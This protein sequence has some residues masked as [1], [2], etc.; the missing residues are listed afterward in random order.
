M[1]ASY[2]VFGDVHKDPLRSIVLT[3]NRWSVAA[4]GSP[5]GTKAYTGPQPLESIADEVGKQIT[6]Y[7]LRSRETVFVHNLL[8]DDRFANADKSVICMPIVH[9]NK[10]LLGSIF[11]EAPPNSFTDRNVTVLRLL[12][13]Q[14]SISLANALLFKR[15]QKALELQKHSLDMAR[16]AE[17]KA[18]EAEAV[19]VQSAQAKALFTAN[20]SHE[21]RTPLNGV[22]GIAELLKDTRPL[23]KEQASYT[24]SIRV[25]ADL[26]LSLINDLLDF[27]KLEAGKMKIFSVPLNL[28]E[29][30]S[31][32]IRALS[33]QN[34]EKGLRTIEQFELPS[35]LFVL[36]DPVRLHQILM[37]ILGNAFKFTFEGAITVRAVVDREDEGSI[38]V[39]FGINDTGIGISESGKAALFR[40]FSQGWLRPPMSL[41]A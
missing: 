41:C 15:L 18:K 1:L 10:V 38:D 37:N 17:T 35:D 19:A 20:V 9:G 21:L 6:L 7:V 30:I 34:K 4:V 16:E 27:T 33:F 5:D 12:V 2:K 28:T 39:T 8:N 11:I 40:P 22:I 14:I 31:E 24:D 29:T 23:S 26:L 13:N 36:G 25:C 3:N 32:V